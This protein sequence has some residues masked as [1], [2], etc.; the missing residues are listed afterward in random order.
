MFVILCGRNPLYLGV[1][2]VGFLLIKAVWVQL[3][4]A[5]EFR[6]GV[7]SIFYCYLYNLLFIPNVHIYRVSLA[8]LSFFA[9]YSQ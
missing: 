1:I 9:T 7:V 3:N 5:G 6:H 2:F 8:C 4:I